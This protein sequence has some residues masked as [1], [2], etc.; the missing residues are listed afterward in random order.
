MSAIFLAATILGVVRGW[1]YE[2]SI[3]ALLGLL[4]VIRLGLHVR[5]VR[6][7][8]LLQRNPEIERT[9]YR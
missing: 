6:L 3:S 5:K 8:R 4:Y 1:G 2:T 7:A 9:Y